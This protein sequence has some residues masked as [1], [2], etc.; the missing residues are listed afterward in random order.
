V[1]QF[2]ESATDLL[3]G[4]SEIVFVVGH[5]LPPPLHLGRNLRDIVPKHDDIVFIAIDIPNMFAQ[6]RLDLE[7][8]ALKQRKFVLAGDVL[9]STC[10]ER[11][12]SSWGTF[13]RA[14]KLP[15]CRYRR[16]RDSNWL[17]TSRLQRRLDLIFRQHS[18][19]RADEVIE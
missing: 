4:P 3:I 1:L 12:P 2:F 7:A 17:S 15:T 9:R 14:R 5:R 8:K 6:Q 11:V 19:E 13:S 16:F 10:N 18:S